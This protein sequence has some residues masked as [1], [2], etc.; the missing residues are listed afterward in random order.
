MLII[1]IIKADRNKKNK[2]DMY[3]TT[4]PVFII[5]Y[6]LSSRLYCRY[7]SFNGSAIVLVQILS[8]SSRTVTAGRELHPALKISAANI[9]ILSYGCTFDC[10]FFVKKERGQCYSTLASPD[11]IL[12]ILKLLLWFIQNCQDIL[13]L[14]VCR[15]VLRY[16][17]EVLRCMNLL[18]Q[19]CLRFP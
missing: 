2:N 5:T 8:K 13:L 17:Q 19:T 18:L 15:S 7:R 4:Y 9:E 10:L 12:N 6:L 16:Q 14:P 1:R 11:K 3:Q